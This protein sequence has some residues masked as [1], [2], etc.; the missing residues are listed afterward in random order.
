MCGIVG[1]IGKQDAQEILMSGLR[2][3]EY[4]GYDSAGIALLCEEGNPEVKVIKREGALSE[5]L[6]AALEKGSFSQSGIGIG[7]TR[8]ATHGAPS[9]RNAHPHTDC[10]QQIAVVHNGIIENY[11][12]LQ[13]DLEQLGHCIQTEVDSEVI[14]HLIEHFKNEDHDILSAVRETVRRLQGAYAL[15]IV[16]HSSNSSLIGVRQDSPLVVGIGDGENYLASDVAALLPYTRDVIILE[17]GDLAHLTVD[18]V[19]I[20]D[21]DGVVIERSITHVDWDAEMAEK[22]GYPHFMLKEIEEQPASWEATLQGRI[23][24]GD[25]H[26]PEITFTRADLETVEQIYLVGCGTSFHAGLAAMP[27]FENLLRMPVRTEIASEFRY[28]DPVLGP[29]V[30]TVFISQSGE[31]ADTLACLELAA[32]HGAQTVAIT[33]V[34]GSSLSRKAD[35][36]IY[37]RAGPEISVASTKT[38]TAQLLVLQLLA[39]HLT[40]LSGLLAGHEMS[41]DVRALLKEMPHLP[42]KM[43]DLLQDHAPIKEMA[44]YVAGWQDAF[45]IGR[46]LDYA[47]AME[48]QLKLKEISYIHAE[49]YPAGELKHGTL[50]LVE[51]GIPVLAVSTQAHLRSKMSSNIEEVRARGG[52]IGLVTDLKE[53]RLIDMA[54][55]V[56]FVPPTAPSLAPL[57]VAG[58]LQLLAYYAAVLRGCPVDMPRNLAK[59]VTV[60]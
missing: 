15:A 27:M 33:N 52:W 7:H 42:Q 46:G 3:L 58:V 19:V 14:P 13:A 6:E 38:Y 55:S 4:R 22:G 50:A 20:Y 5:G 16:D 43:R 32:K 24:N 30:L 1:Y 21:E 39:C 41:E 35:H 57:L 18:D 59:S 47:A 2:R 31:T 28:R 10:H 56:I 29:E 11:S 26:L 9:D 60:E 8:W 54:Q 49:A 53:G 44:R 48:G 45:F 36:V 51:P 25:I 23:K 40:R 12:E 34:V 37:T 17:N